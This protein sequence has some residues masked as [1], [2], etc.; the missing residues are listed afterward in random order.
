MFK[1]KKTIFQAY[2]PLA[3]V[4]MF[5]ST[6]VFSFN[7]VDDFGTGFTA[8]FSSGKYA[9]YPVEKCFEIGGNTG[10]CL[11]NNFG[12]S[13]IIEFVNPVDITNFVYILSTD[14]MNFIVD[15]VS[16]L[17]SEVNNL[18]HYENVSTMTFN[19][20]ANNYIW[21]DFIGFN[22]ENA[23]V[24]DDGSDNDIANGIVWGLFAYSFTV[25]G[26]FS[27]IGRGIKSIIDMVKYG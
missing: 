8:Y 16:Y 7:S 11:G 2:Y 15:D 21:I 13:L 20:F 1:I 22:F 24:V 23:A 10:S 14:F 19:A 26:V 3:L 17:A 5:F 25:V 27:L 6:P 9:G 4:L 12:D 18:S